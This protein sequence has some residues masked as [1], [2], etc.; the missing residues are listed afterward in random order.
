MP[1]AHAVGG[2]CSRSPAPGG[3]LVSLRRDIQMHSVRHAP[4]LPLRQYCLAELSGEMHST[5]LR[6]HYIAELSGAVSYCVQI[7]VSGNIILR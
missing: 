2:T 4:L 1:D 5:P 6:R 7:G 3:L